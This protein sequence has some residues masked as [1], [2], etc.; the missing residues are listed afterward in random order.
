MSNDRLALVVGGVA[1]VVATSTL[2]LALVTWAQ[3]RARSARGA[4][5]NRGTQTW[6]SWSLPGITASTGQ[7]TS[8]NDT[9]RLMARL[10]AAQLALA[11]TRD[12]DGELWVRRVD[13]D[14]ALGGES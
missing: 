5:P 7:A 1:L 14:R 3:V 2:V 9:R 10:V 11:P 4:P 12:I 6:S 8:V 13:V